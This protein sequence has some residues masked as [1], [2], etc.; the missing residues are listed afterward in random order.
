[1]PG[2]QLV[3]GATVQPLTVEQVKN[4]LRITASDVALNLDLER[5]LK[6]ATRWVES[7]T[8]RA[9]LS[10]SW[11]YWFDTFPSYGAHGY[12]VIEI[13]KAPILSI[14]TVSSYT[15]E[16]V[17]TLFDADGYVT[18]LTRG[19]VLLNDGSTWPTD[20]RRYQGGV[21]AFTA[22]YGATAD[23]VPADLV[24]AV[25][26]MVGY[27]HYDREGIDPVPQKAL[28]LIAAYELVAA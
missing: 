5:K 26:E 13:P 12:S 18:D 28:D 2:L 27:M 22:G 14:E 9:L 7:R 15:S 20:V 17:L 23:D 19:R 6:A 16:N 1:M 3:A 24:E 10:Q 25:A 11:R 21:I 8:G 4:H